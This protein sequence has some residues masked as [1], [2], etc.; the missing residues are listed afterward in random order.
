[1]TQIVLGLSAVVV[2]VS[3]DAPF[4]LVTRDRDQALTSL[5]FG[6]FDPAGDR[7][8]E[9]TLR[10]WV[11]AQTG[12]EIG[13]VEQLYT[14][15]DRG[16]EA[17]LAA[18]A[19]RVLSI[20]YLAL[21]PDKV[22]VDAA[23]AGWR[24]WYDYFPWEDWRNGRPAVIDAVIAPRLRDW[25]GGRPERRDRARLA[26]ALDGA[27]WN[28]ERA[29]E[30]YELVYE[31]GLAPEAQRDARRFEGQAG[32]EV[33]ASAPT[34]GLGEPMRS[35]HRRILATAISRL[36]GKLKYRPVVFEL[37]PERFTL[38]HLQRVVEAI[39]GIELHKQNFRRLLE[40]GT[41]VVGTGEL[42]ARTGG[43]PA[44]LFR[45]RR[46]VLRERP[47]GGFHVPAP[48]GASTE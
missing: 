8:L 31:A 38:L 11:T 35:D 3:E 32:V 2:A 6:L 1:M 46:E 20:G 12:F 14:F 30:R 43:R 29:L 39:S 10:K 19:D 33:E 15:G 18:D 16:R 7:T 45:F 22:T 44:E 36:R 26:F 5:P 48:K 27:A 4:V 9:L 42:E 17:P 13:Y 34:A 40:R 41:L 21:A 24:D 37:M 47:V 25:A 28:E 23:G